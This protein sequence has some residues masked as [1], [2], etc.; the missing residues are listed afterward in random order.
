MLRPAWLLP[1]K[2]LSTPRSGKGDLS[3][4][5]GSATRRSDAYR[6]GTSTRWVCAAEPAAQGSGLLAF[7]THHGGSLA[8]SAIFAIDETTARGRLRT[9]R[10]PRSAMPSWPWR[11]GASGDTDATGVRVRS[12]PSTRPVRGVGHRTVRPGEH[13]ELLADQVP[14]CLR[15]AV[16]NG[17]RSRSPVQA[18]AGTFM[19]RV[20]NQGSNLRPAG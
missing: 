7:V 4:H 2:R 17:P 15:L 10:P 19:Q 13:D 16:P 8:L 12:N 5:L 6:D 14:E 3:P 11:S 18:V 20:P 1:P 9:Q